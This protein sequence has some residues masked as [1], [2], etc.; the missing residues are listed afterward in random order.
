MSRN[1]TSLAK[2]ALGHFLDQRGWP[3]ENGKI[4]PPPDIETEKREL[5]SISNV[6]TKSYPHGIHGMGFSIEGEQYLCF[7]I[8]RKSVFGTFFSS[9]PIDFLEAELKGASLLYIIEKLRLSPFAVS[10]D[11][12]EQRVVGPAT[13]HDGVDLAELLQFYPKLQIFKFNNSGRFSENTS[14]D[15]LLLYLATYHPEVVKRCQLNDDSIESLRDLILEEKPWVHKNN[16]FDA[17]TASHLRHAFLEVYRCLEF[18]FVLPR[19]K[20]LMSG[21]RSSGGSVT[22]DPITFAKMC[23]EK[24]GWRRIERDSIETIFRALLEHS[25]ADFF[26]AAEN[27]SATK[28]AVVPLQNEIEKVNTTISQVAQRYYDVRNQVAHQFWPN[29]MRDMNSDDWN[30]LIR[31][32]AF[33]I[34]NYH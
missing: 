1:L 17:M 4:T 19:A 18:A 12:V 30:A 15:I 13:S 7:P 33:C 26:A 25:Y 14:I 22:E 2:Y 21:I 11:E 8:E 32:T 23:A 5:D 31:L 27:C 10:G 9:V 29:Q 28:P 6:V 3:V 16:I 24:L 20:E 34:K